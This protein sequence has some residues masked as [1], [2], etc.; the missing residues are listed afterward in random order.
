M[1]KTAGILVA[2]SLNACQSTRDHSDSGVFDRADS[3]VARA[4]FCRHN[5]DFRRIIRATPGVSDNYKLEAGTDDYGSGDSGRES[6]MARRVDVDF[7][8]SEPHG[9]VP[10]I[11][12]F[13]ADNLAMTLW[14]TEDSQLA[15]SR[16]EGDRTVLFNA[17]VTS[18]LRASFKGNYTCIENGYLAL[19]IR[20]N[21]PDG[22]YSISV[23]AFDP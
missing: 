5:D 13:S 8:R 16:I 20:G 15:P 19:I 3:S 14:Y 17:Y 1:K 10:Y 12:H 22:G 6:V 23:N 18:G 11:G 9:D 7:S 21:E 4:Y 2:L